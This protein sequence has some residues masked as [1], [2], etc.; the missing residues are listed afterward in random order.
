MMVYGQMKRTREDAI[1]VYFKVPPH[2]VP[3]TFEETI[4][5]SFITAGAQ[6]EI[7]TKYFLNTIN[8][9]IEGYY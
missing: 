8:V 4:K 6:A 3:V 7:H 5:T 2:Y 9:C 1:V